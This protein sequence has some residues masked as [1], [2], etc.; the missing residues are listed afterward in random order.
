[1][2]EIGLHPLFGE[3]CRRAEPGAQRGGKCARSQ[4]PFLSAAVDQF[5]DL[6]PV[7]HPQRAD[8]LGTIELV[9]GDR[10]QVCPF[11]RGQLAG[12]L[13]RIAQ[14]QRADL[15]RPFGQPAGRLDRADLVVDL[16]HRDQPGALGDRHLG[17]DQAIGTDR[18][19][20]QVC[21]GRDGRIDHRR[22]LDRADR[23]WSARDRAD[24]LVQR[25][26]RTAGEDHP[27]APGQQRRDLLARQ[28]NRRRCRPARAVHRVRIG[29]A[30][31]LGPGQ[32][33]L[34]CRARFRRE[35]GGRL[36]VKVDESGGHARNRCFSDLHFYIA[37]ASRS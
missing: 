8:P 10:D 15:V 32:P 17:I 2:L 33:R 9:R 11:G 7:A 30:H 29:E 34:H 16:H 22:M 20:L 26:G 35:R 36:V 21:S 31:I 25:L 14:E 27:A 24:C 3:R 28:L 4:P 12:A 1:M 37:P 23:D 19:L 18:Q 6:R 13:H 5:A